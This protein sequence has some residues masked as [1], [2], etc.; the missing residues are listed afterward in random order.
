M[1]ALIGTRHV[2][3]SGRDN[4]LKR[5][6]QRFISRDFDGLVTMA[7]ERHLPPG[8]REVRKWP[9]L[10]LGIVPRFDPKEWDLRVDGSVDK[11]VR[12]TYDELLRLP[13]TKVMSAFHC[14]T[15]WTTFDNEWIGVTI[16]EVAER[17]K[18]RPTAPIPT[19]RCGDGSTT[20]PTL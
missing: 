16:K 8:Q 15:G 13:S 17:A 11:P 5:E 2:M 18:N 3:E 10:D 7:A 14:V 1:R 9:R 4:A 19:L 20:S 6:A 12:F